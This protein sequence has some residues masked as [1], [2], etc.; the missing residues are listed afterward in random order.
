MSGVQCTAWTTVYIF[1]HYWT[2]MNYG[3]L[4]H[5]S[6][7]T[8]D[9]TTQYH[10]GH[11]ITGVMPSPMLLMILT[12]RQALPSINRWSDCIGYRIEIV[13]LIGTLSTILQ[14]CTH[15]MKPSDPLLLADGTLHCG[16]YPAGKVAISWHLITPRV[17]PVQCDH[18]VGK[19]SADAGSLSSEV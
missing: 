14:H 19:L 12:P 16:M 18:T 1:G 8:M 11:P 13:C 9:N 17:L 15:T 7:S 6:M 3:A 4:L 10:G 2:R 5:S